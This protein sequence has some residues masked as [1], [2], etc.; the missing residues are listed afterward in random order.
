M[1]AQE[2]AE[3]AHH[4]YTVLMRGHQALSGPLTLEEAIARALK[5]N[6]AAELTRVE[7]TL[8]DRQVDLAV[9]QML[10]RLAADAGYSWR[11]TYDAARSIDVV[12]GRQALD[13]AYSQEPQRG[14]VSLQFSWNILDAGVS[15]FQARQ[16][17]YRAMIAVERRR[18]VIDT[19]VT[20][21]QEAYRRA[22]VAHALLPKLETLTADAQRLL[23]AG[24]ID[25]H[26]RQAVNAHAL[27]TRQT[28]LEI[29]SQ[30]RHMKNTLESS[31]LRLATL[32]NVPIDSQIDIAASL[33]LRLAKPASID[34]AG[35]EETSLNLR[36]ELREAAYEEKIDRQDIYKEII[37]MLPGIGLL[38]SLSYDNN[39]LLYNSVWGEMGLRASYN[40]ISLIEG[41]KAI[42]VAKSAVEVA[43]TRRLALAVAVLTQINLSVQDYQNAVDELNATIEMDKLQQDLIISLAKVAGAKS[44]AAR[45]RRELGAITASYEHGRALTDAY[46]ALANLYV[47]AGE[48]LVTPDVD[49]SDLNRLIVAVRVAIARWTHGQMPMPIMLTASAEAP[50]VH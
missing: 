24:Q 28:L 16:E 5:F 45:I 2:Q 27:E 50:S 11:N 41:P 7:A 6:Y 10:P 48:D 39:R 32:I 46:T 20:S 25:I 40:L 22:V 8:Q 31:Q 34:I 49:I 14:Y 18:K 19:I 42:Q 23:D 38:G 26:P 36:P 15:Y 30:L 13:Y 3:R 43:K 12:N 44:E 29:I 1:S 35:L 4:D 21:V 17:G 9:T 37:N 33:D 47:A